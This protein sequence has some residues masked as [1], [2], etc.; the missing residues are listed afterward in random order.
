MK[1]TKILKNYFDLFSK[2]DTDK[3]NLLFSDDITPRL[4]IKNEIKKSDFL[5]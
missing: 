5:Q 4:D 3:L 1:S 2:K